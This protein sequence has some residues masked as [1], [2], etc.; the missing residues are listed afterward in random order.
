MSIYWRFRSDTG[1]AVPPPELPARSR[2]MKQ[3]GGTRPHF[4]RL[5]LQSAFPKVDIVNK[6]E[7]RDILPGR[8]RGTSDVQ[9]QHPFWDAT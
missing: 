6:S 1:Q 4:G 8:Y 9:D 7:T 2:N 5:K 3:T